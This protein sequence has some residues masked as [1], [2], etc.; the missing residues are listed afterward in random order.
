[1]RRIAPGQS[2]GRLVGG[3]VTET[4]HHFA[5]GQSLHETPRFDSR[6][7]SHIGA[8]HAEEL[9]PGKKLTTLLSAASWNKLIFLR[10]GNYSTRKYLSLLDKYV[11]FFIVLK[12]AQD[13][14]LTLP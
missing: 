11:K 2:F 7:R 3:F 9:V 10:L 4:Q 13:M 14:Q 8:V 12:H 1:M 5:V 6:H